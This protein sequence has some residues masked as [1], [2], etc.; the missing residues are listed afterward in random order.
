[1]KKLISV[2]VPAYNEE[3]CAQ[4][5]YDKLA[6]VTSKIP[7]Y[8]FEFII[9]ENGSYDKTY[10]KLLEINDRDSRFKII[11]LSRNCGADNAISIGLRYAKGDA[12]FITYAD[13][14]DPPEYLEVFIKKWEEGYEN[15]YGITK[16]RQTGFIRNLN[17]KLFYWLMNRLTDGIIPKGVADFRLVDRSL[18]SAV[19]DFPEKNKF[20]RGLFAWSQFKSIGVEYNRNTVRAGG[21][22]KASTL[23]VIRLATRAICSFSTFPLRISTALGIIFFIISLLGM[24][25]I[26]ISALI[27]GLPFKG[28]GTIICTILALFSVNFLILGIIGEYVGLIFEEVK[29]RPITIIKEKIGISD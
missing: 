10:E 28:F 9:V 23:N 19:A 2:I 1:M 11:R 12:A 25:Y 4:A 14:E 22:S 5:L 17:S 18:Y 8:N 15:V 29:A 16:R 3:E 20:L 24:T 27:F 21:I 13:L 26:I 7:A 6:D